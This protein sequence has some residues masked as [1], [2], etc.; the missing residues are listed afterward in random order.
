MH[1]GQFLKNEMEKRGIT[2]VHAGKIMNK[3][4][5]GVAKDFTKE[6]LTQDVIEE[7]SK[8]LGIN[9]FKILADEFEGKPYQPSEENQLMTAEEET[10]ERQSTAPSQGIEILSVNIAVP[11]DKKE[12]IL[13]LLMS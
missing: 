10:E 13:Q 2:N 3:T 5:S 12:A 4:G 6:Q 9:I 7:W 8:F 1:L 11:Q